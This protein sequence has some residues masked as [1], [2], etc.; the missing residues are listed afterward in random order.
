MNPL[1]RN[2]DSK[3]VLCKQLNKKE[4]IVSQNMWDAVKA[5]P[6]GKFIH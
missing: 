4:S 1:G 3:C 5:V 2:Y 6:K